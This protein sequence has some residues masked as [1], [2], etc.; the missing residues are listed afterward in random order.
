MNSEM[1]RPP[2]RPPKPVVVMSDW[3]IQQQLDREAPKLKRVMQ[4]I[5]V[6]FENIRGFLTT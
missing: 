5:V 4:V 6:E 2:G 3:K 1:K